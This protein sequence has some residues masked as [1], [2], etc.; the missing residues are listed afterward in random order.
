VSCRAHRARQF[1]RRR[2]LGRQGEPPG[3][4][5][6]G[7]PG[8]KRLMSPRRGCSSPVNAHGAHHRREALQDAESRRRRRKRQTRGGGPRCCRRFAVVGGGMSAASGSACGCL[9]RDHS[10]S[11]GVVV[12][13][14]TGDEQMQ[15][16]EVGRR[17][18]AAAGGSSSLAGRCP[19]P[20][21]PSVLCSRRGEGRREEERW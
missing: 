3:P 2:G 4:L 15:Q 1:A 18:A 16:L 21:R 9:L 17:R 19:R 5:H 13:P 8:R 20:Q 12:S 14:R 7:A 10:A 6:R 11:C